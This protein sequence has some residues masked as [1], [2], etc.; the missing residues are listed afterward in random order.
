MVAHSHSFV[1]VI[2]IA[3]VVFLARVV[4]RFCPHSFVCVIVTQLRTFL[5]SQFGLNIPT[6]FVCGPSS[7]VIVIAVVVFLARVVGRFCPHSFVCVIVSQLRTFLPSQFCLNMPTI[8]V[9]G[10][11]SFVN[12][13]TFLYFEITFVN[14]SVLQRYINH[15]YVLLLSYVGL[16]HLIN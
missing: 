9:C 6:I 16:N 5:P 15:S 10:P 12:I 4:G 3:A 2:V 1:C 8:F 7:F 11:S 13:S 14:E